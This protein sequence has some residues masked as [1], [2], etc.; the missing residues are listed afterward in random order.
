MAPSHLPACK[1]HKGPILI[2]HSLPLTFLL[3]NSFCAE[4]SRIGALWSPQKWHHCLFHRYPL[5]GTVL[6]P[7]LDALACWS[8]YSTSTCVLS[9][10]SISGTDFTFLLLCSAHLL[11]SLLLTAG[12]VKGLVESHTIKS[13]QRKDAK[14]NQNVSYFT[15]WSQLWGLLHLHWKDFPLSFKVFHFF[16]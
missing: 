9:D 12:L 16:I 13:G 14:P 7:D 5:H 4:T 1:P 2:N 6:L 8:L 15:M 11:Q 3:L 10:H